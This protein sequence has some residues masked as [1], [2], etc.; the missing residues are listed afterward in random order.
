MK[1]L[2]LFSVLIISLLF[3]ANAGYVIRSIQINPP[4]ADDLKNYTLAF[5][6]D[7]T[8]ISAASMHSSVY[9]SG[10]GKNSI[11]IVQSDVIGA[12]IFPIAPLTAPDTP[13]DIEVRDFYY[14]SYSEVYVLCGSRRSGLTTNAFVAVINATF[15]AMRFQEYPE[16]D[17]FY[18]ICKPSP[19]SNYFLCGKSGMQGVIA[20]VSKGALQL[21]NF[22][23]TNTDWEYH[24]I[25]AIPSMGTPLTPSFFVSGRNPGCTR[26][27]FT[28]LNVSFTPLNT[29][30]WGQTTDPQSHCVISEDVSGN[31][32]VILAS[33]NG[34]IVTLNP[35]TFSPTTTIS[36][37]R[38]GSPNLTYYF[39]QD[40]GIIKIGNT[41]RISVAGFKR[42]TTVQTKAWHGH[43]D[44]LPNNMT[45][46][47][48]YGPIPI[49]K[50]EHY[51]IRYQQISP[52]VYKE[53][54]GGYFEGTG[55]MG[56][57]FGSPLTSPDMCGDLYPIDFIDSHNLTWSTF[58]LTS[59]IPAPTSYVSYL[60]DLYE[61]EF[62]YPCDILKG[63]DPAP[64]LVM[65]VEDESEITTFYDRIIVRDVPTNTNYKIYN[66]VG[67]LVQTGITYP[68]ISIAQLNKGIYILKLENGKAFKFVK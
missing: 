47:D 61:M 48:Y 55:E 33:S 59:P 7:G 26:I 63:G 11:I 56:A 19:S 39:V 46:N 49:G 50:Y 27:G 66:V 16:A 21:A 60:S 2:V 4:I 15:S 68:D 37:Y 35:V 13:N 62:D 10:I 36:A 43:V 1:K 12:Y 42:G 44:G 22:Y 41:A 64:E 67:Q 34:N 45:N 52:S 5:R 23:I 32:S 40:I 14:D 58:L 8:P 20:S 17:I 65:P 51:K 6:D 28:T 24:K 18:S 9:G 38:Y 31:N 30:M 53:Y 29:Y 25:T 3:T 54:T 57:L